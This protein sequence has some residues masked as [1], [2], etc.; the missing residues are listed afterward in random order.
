MHDRMQNYRTFFLEYKKKLYH[1][2]QTS[3]D[4][5]AITH[6]SVFTNETNFLHQLRRISSDTWKHKAAQVDTR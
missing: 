5:N 6:P 4:V 3:S 2:E 1:M